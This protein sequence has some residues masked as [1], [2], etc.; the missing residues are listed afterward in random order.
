MADG[1]QTKNERR[2]TKIESGRASAVTGMTAD[3]KKPLRLVAEAAPGQAVRVPD[4]F[5]AATC[6]VRSVPPP[7]L[8]AS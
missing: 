7:L 2:R 8:S 1:E 6:L 5:F 3:G 4:Q